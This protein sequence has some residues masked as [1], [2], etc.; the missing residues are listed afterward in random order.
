MK[1]RHKFLA[2]L[3]EM[4]R[5]WSLTH[6]EQSTSYYVIVLGFFTELCYLL[7]HSSPIRN[8]VFIGEKNNLIVMS[9]SKIYIRKNINIIWNLW[10]K[11]L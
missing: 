2:K 3:R 1:I 4:R 11:S 10:D 7:E 8:C 5:V 9:P 6:L